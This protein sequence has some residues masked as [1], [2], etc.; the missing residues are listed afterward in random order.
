MCQS[1]ALEHIK[2]NFN[3]HSQGMKALRW[4]RGET[5]QHCH[6]VEDRLKAGKCSVD[7]IFNNDSTN[8]TGLDIKNNVRYKEGLRLELG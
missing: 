6:L 5:R 4:A 8:R 7:L 2:A 3:G 1:E